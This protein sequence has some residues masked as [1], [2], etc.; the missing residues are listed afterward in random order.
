MNRSIALLS[1]VAAGLLGQTNHANA[2]GFNSETDYVYVETNIMTP[3][4]N[5][6]AA[7]SRGSNGQLQQIPGSPFLTGGAGTQYTGVA[8]GPEDSDQDVISN[9]DHT[10]LFAV[11]SG[12]DSIAV[13]HIKANGSLVPV[14]GSPFSSGG[15]DPVSL[16]LVGNIL[17]VV[18]KSGDFGRPSA[19]LPNY[20]TLQVR[21]NGSL[22][23]TPES[24][25]DTAHGYQSAVSVA[26]GSSPSQAHVVPNTDLLFGTD[27]LGGL[28][29]RF[30]F[31]N[32]GGLHQLSPLAL[33][34]SEFTDTTTGRLPL[35]LWHH[36]SLPLIYVG[37][38]TDNKLGVYE[39]NEKGRLAFIRTVPN[40]GQAICWIRTNRKGTRL[41]STDTG[42][43]S[44][45]VYDLNNP[46]EPKQI[47]RLVLSG[48]GNALQ[49][50][51]STDEKSL[52]ALSSRGSTS[53]PEG[54]GNVLHVLTIQQDG[55]V[56]ETVSP[57]V[58][59]LPNDT[60]PQ[61]IAVV[62]AN[63]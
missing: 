26:A 22:T 15:N 21:N 11:N 54:Q 53:I 29:Q 58:F 49:F 27:F 32:T 57:V 50:S 30:R 60:R 45:S 40:S 5:S 3:N 10:L 23:P 61:G 55:T 34:A 63:E 17:F 48:V 19:V 31:D 1:L 25:N 28:I 7:F 35:D 51:L 46:E 2:A 12:S 43:N 41:Y 24:T 14:D 56:A 9:R 36:P 4:G 52:Y 59:Q 13:F 38:V 42:T 44:V 33:P 37:F 18:N 47:Q 20:T 39:Y 8:V 6:I 16:D 62:P